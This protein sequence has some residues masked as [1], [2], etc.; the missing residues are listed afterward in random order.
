MN[1]IIPNNALVQYYAYKYRIPELSKMLI[2]TRFEHAI[3]AL[4][5][6]ISFAERRKLGYYEFPHGAI[7]LY[8]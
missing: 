7:R 3:G 8:R 1:K 5:N 6:I 2:Y 4:T